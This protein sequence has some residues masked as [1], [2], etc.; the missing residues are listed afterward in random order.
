MEPLAALLEDSERH[1]RSYTEIDLTETNYLCLAGHEADTETP[2]NL[3]SP[4]AGR[5]DEPTRFTVSAYKV[6]LFVF[7]G[8][9]LFL[10]GVF[11]QFLSGLWRAHKTSIVYSFLT[12]L[13]TSSNQ[14]QGL[15]E[16]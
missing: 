5:Q 11:V 14:V 7:F 13:I 16:S 2:R 9:V 15:P 4:H 10:L 12:P 3:S 1:G 6:V 8:L